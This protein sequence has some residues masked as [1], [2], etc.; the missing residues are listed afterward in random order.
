MTLTFRRRALSSL[1]VPPILRR[2]LSPG[3]ICNAGDEAGAMAV[4]A[5]TG[6]RRCSADVGG[7]LP[8]PEAGHLPSV[9]LQ[10]SL[11]L[12]SKSTKFQRP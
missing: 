8:R 1:G 3:H 11:S 4:T 6:S 12:H 7:V 2:V 5:Y 10:V 9:G